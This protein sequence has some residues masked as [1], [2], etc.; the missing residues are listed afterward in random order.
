MTEISRN[1]EKAKSLASAL[2]K[3]T[4]MQQFFLN[5]N[6]LMKRSPDIGWCTSEKHDFTAYQIEHPC[7]TQQRT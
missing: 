3:N 4:A 1:E 6:G 5:G 2:K 7:E